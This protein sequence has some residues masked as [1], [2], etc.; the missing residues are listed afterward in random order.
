[1]LASR[2]G[3]RCVRSRRTEPTGEQHR[4]MCKWRRIC[5]KKKRQQMSRESV[6][7]RAFTSFL[8]LEQMPSISSSENRPVPQQEI[9][10]SEIDFSRQEMSVN[11]R[12]SQLMI[13]VYEDLNLGIYFGTF[14]GIF[15]QIFWFF[16]Y[17]ILGLFW[18]FC[19]FLWDIGTFLGF[20][21]LFRIFLVFSVSDFGTFSI[22]VIFLGDFEIFFAL[23][24]F[25]G[26]FWDIFLGFS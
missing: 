14:L 16:L 11:P 19:D 1:M 4:M 23:L 22:F 7:P 21:D 9:D 13:R 2:A 17:W 26:E 5:S 15:F 25:F 8:I 6:I 10:W 3:K 24:R 12:G 20:R 18:G